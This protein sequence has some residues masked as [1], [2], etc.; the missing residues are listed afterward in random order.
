MILAIA[1]FALMGNMGVE[2]FDLPWVQAVV[3][4]FDQLGWALFG[5]SLVVSCFTAGITGLGTGIGDVGQDIITKVIASVV[6][7]K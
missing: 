1:F 4:F 7:G 6:G 2:L 3:R 5:V